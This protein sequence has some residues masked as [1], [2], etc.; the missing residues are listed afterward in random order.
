M[1]TLISLRSDTLFNNLW[2][3]L[4]KEANTLGTEE[5]SLPRKR[6][7][8]GKLLSGNGT[9]FYCDIEEVVIYYNCVYFNAIRFNQPGFRACQNIEQ[10]LLNAV[11]NKNYEEQLKNVLAVYGDD[12]DIITLTAQ[13]ESLKVNFSSDEH[14][15]KDITETL[16]TFSV[17]FRESV[18]NLRRIK[19][20][21]CTSMT[22][23][24]LNHCMILS[25]HK[26]RTK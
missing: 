11:N 19:D 21:L 5:L 1:K 26:E 6:K 20:W 2:E 18:F 3:N 10:L 7:R 16:Q 17:N 13:L 24:R 8:N 15:I 14:S 23:K 22:Q 4:K 25:V 12:L 9:Q